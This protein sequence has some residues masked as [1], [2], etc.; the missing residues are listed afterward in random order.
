MRAL[1]ERISPGVDAVSG[2]A[3][4]L[5]LAAG[6]ADAVTVG[7]AFHWFDAVTATSEI[8]RVLRERGVLALVWNIRDLGDPLQARIN[9]LLRPVRRGTPS[10]HEQ[11]WRDVLARS[12]SFG[13]AE[14]RSFAWAQSQT[15]EELVDRIA[16][17]SFVARLAE[18]ARKELLEQ[19]REEV[20]A[21][22]QPFDFH[23]R[24]DVYVF[25]RS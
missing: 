21:L 24:T 22:P 16:S 20:A 8:A 12:D 2:T 3:E 15:T 9:E 11:P 17:V 14:E 4:E 7:Q 6:S 18:S 19:V 1:L 25:E 23:Y 13:G 10:E 5:P